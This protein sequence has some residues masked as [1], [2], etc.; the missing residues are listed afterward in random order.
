ML[1][2]LDRDGVINQDAPEG[3]LHPNDFHFLPRSAQAIA[4]LTAHGF[5]IAVCT[6]QSAVGRGRMT[7]ETLDAIHEKMLH[8]VRALGG[9]I[10]RIYVATDVP[11]AQSTHRK[12]APG[13][14]LDA[15]RD[16][17][18]SAA[19]TFF[20]GDMAR[21][22]EAAF[23]A[24]CPRMLVRTGKGAHTEQQGLH[25]PWAPVMVFDDLSAAAQHLADK[26]PSLR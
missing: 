11:N 10:A 4:A 15:L 19:H 1:V 17:S 9:D 14:L 6:N 13:M 23:H 3:I 2:L 26:P 8:G 22:M 24:G 5:R 25:Q 16:F 7:Q 20:I 12:P 18:A 21:D